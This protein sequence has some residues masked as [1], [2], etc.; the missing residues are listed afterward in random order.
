M[1]IVKGVITAVV[2]CLRDL[3]NSHASPSSEIPPKI[4]K[5][6]PMIADVESLPEAELSA[7]IVI[8]WFGTLKK[9]R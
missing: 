1:L 2:A 4:P 6:M 3:H 9:M 8:F 7:A 5:A